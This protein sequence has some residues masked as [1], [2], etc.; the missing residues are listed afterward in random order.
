M[1]VCPREFRIDGILSRR[2]DEILPSGAAG[3]V[4]RIGM[5][6]DQL[7][8]PPESAYIGRAVVTRRQASGAAR[9][10]A[11]SSLSSISRPPPISIGRRGARRSGRP[12]SSDRL[13]MMS[14]WPP[15]SWGLQPRSVDLASM[16]NQLNL[17]M[18]SSSRLLPLLKSIAPLVP[19]ARSQFWT[20]ECLKDL[21]RQM[22]YRSLATEAGA[23]SCTAW[24]RVVI[25][26]AGA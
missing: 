8:S 22:L 20:S 7:L 23:R 21:N 19:S 18:T 3:A 12:E 9:M 11:R 26:F 4:R 16:S 25:P 13:V 15:R 14:W 17:S 6:D 24:F 10:L 2:L 5:K 1:F